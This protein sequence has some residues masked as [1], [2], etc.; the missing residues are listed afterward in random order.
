M[1]LAKKRNDCKYTI[2]Q[3]NENNSACVVIDTPSKF[4]ERKKIVEK[5]ILDCLKVRILILYEYRDRL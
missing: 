2:F 4:S 5:S 3:I 1:S